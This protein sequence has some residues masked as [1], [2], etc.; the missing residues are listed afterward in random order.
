MKKSYDMPDILR[1]CKYCK[2]FKN[3]KCYYNWKLII[4]END[5]C[6][7]WKADKNQLYTIVCDL[8]NKL[9]KCNNN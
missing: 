3:N 1:I 4:G 2:A 8:Y 7:S 9:E 5:T 6:S